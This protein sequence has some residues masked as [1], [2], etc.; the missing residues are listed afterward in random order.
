MPYARSIDCMTAAQL[1]S[2]KSIFN[3]SGRWSQMM[4]WMACTC[5]IDRAWFSQLRRPRV[6]GVKPAN[7]C[8][9]KRAIV[10]LT[11]V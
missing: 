1:H 5:A 10:L 7:P 11:A 3:C 4:R 2:A 6:R 8:D 9:S